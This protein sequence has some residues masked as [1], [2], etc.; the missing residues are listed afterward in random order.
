MS[1]TRIGPLPRRAKRVAMFAVCVV[2]VIALAACGSG[3]SGAA[4]KSAVGIVTFSTSD[5]DTNN[6][7]TA[8]TAEATAK[9]WSVDNLNANGS[10]QQANTQIQQLV[11]K[12]VTAIIVTVFD[13]NALASGLAAAKSAGIP[14]LSAGG[15]MASGIA[16][17]TDDGAGQPMVD[18]MLKN[19]GNAGDVLDLTYHP[20]IPCKQRADTFDGTVKKYPAVK[21]TT[22]EISIPG[23]A[24]SAQA[25]TSA[26]LAANTGTSGKQAIFNCYDDDAMGA[27]S[28]LQQDKKTDVQVYSYNA[29]PPALAAVRAGTMTATLWLDLKSAGKI[30][31]DSIPQIRTEGSSWKPHSVIPDYV[32]VTKDNVDSFTKEHA[33][34]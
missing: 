13:S 23:A 18:L 17:A 20:G 3:S 32:I 6:M 26:W 2:S 21:V 14:V 16:L 15:G 12:Q 10:Q 33:S 11:T 22:H 25:A 24:E 31:V 4:S 8:M 19:L 30:L 1:D 5:V 9:G 7:V 27:I 34:G 28:A 29:T